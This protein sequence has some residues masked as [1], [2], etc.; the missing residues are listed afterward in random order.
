MKPKHLPLAWAALFCSV[1]FGASINA[2]PSPVFTGQCNVPTLTSG[3]APCSAN[4]VYIPT[5]GGTAS[6]SASYGLNGPN[7]P[8][9]SASGSGNSAGTAYGGNANLQYQMLISGPG[10]TAQV[11]INYLATMFGTFSPSPLG[12][13][14]SA[15]LDVYFGFQV[16]ADLILANTNPM[17]NVSAFG[18]SSEYG[19]PS[20][21]SDTSIGANFDPG[22]G[23]TGTASGPAILTLPTNSAL[24]VSLT[25]HASCSSSGA[26]CSTSATL[27]PT[28]TI[29]SGQ[30]NAG[31][32]SIQFSPGVG[33]GISA[34][35]A[36]EP[37]TILL[38]GLA[39]AGVGA[40]QRRHPARAA[41]QMP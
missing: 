14:Q 20:S 23:W 41:R 35:S 39:L 28:F 7:G 24:T 1:G 40:I 30:A 22:T 15:G 13:D 21:F 19:L 16:D 33:N 17:I 5:S 37:G 2:L 3:S 4:N 27:D 8:Y 29:D 12:N 11:D 18:G 9:V 10:G 34:S 38:M 26:S 32:Y 6:D 31:Q 25:A 36:P